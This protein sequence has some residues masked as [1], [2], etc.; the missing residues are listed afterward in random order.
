MYPFLVN[1]LRRI[2]PYIPVFV[3]NQSIATGYGKHF[4]DQDIRIIDVESL[5]HRTI[6]SSFWQF[7]RN[8]L[9]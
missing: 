7:I 5:M 2:G 6:M 8:V 1:I 4:F 9:R 3:E